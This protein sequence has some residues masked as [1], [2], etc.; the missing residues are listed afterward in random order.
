MALG[1]ALFCAAGASGLTAAAGLRL[2]EEAFDENV[3]CGHLKLEKGIR[4]AE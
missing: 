1:V 2:S 4:P 3:N